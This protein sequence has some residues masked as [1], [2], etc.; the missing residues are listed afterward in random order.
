MLETSIHGVRILGLATTLP[1]KKEGLF[2]YPIEVYSCSEDQTTSDLGFH[3]AERLLNH[4]D[5][6]KEDIG[7][8]LFGSR[9][10][11]YRSPITAG[12]LQARLSISIDCI[13]YD[14]NVGAT[15]FQQMI[16][17]G[18][19]MLL[20]Q[21]KK[22]GIVIVGDTPSKLRI[23]NQT[24]IFPSSDAATSILLVKDSENFSI[25][26]TNVSIGSKYNASILRSGGFREY[27]PNIPF[28]ASLLENFVVNEDEKV[29]SSEVNRFKK[30]IID[31][32]S[33]GEINLMSQKLL[34]IIEVNDEYT[35]FRQIWSEASELPILL[36]SI[37]RSKIESGKPVRFWSVGEGLSLYSMELDYLPF[38]LPTSQT[39]DV[40]HDH[41][42]NHEM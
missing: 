25:R 13:C 33:V 31:S 17:L 6:D 36:E 1:S 32:N 23:E 20:H 26:F 42:I 28:D 39:D 15:G 3:A 8:I 5:V 21:N 7:F 22:I 40:F 14:V 37:I 11:D 27:N 38:C 2:D 16:Q 19:S 29:I 18:S 10:P 24:T 4:F 35:R 12:I 30:E 41:H 9:T 34:K